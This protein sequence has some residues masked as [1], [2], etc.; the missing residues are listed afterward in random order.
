M[1]LCQY[2]KGCMGCCG[3]DFSSVKEVK[4]AVSLN[5]REFSKIK[6]LKKFRDRVGKWD[7]RSG[8]C[9][10]VVMVRK[11]VFCPLHP[12]R[13]SGKDLRKG[14]CD[15]K[16]LCAT[17][18]KFLKWDKRKQKEFLKFVKGMDT[19]EY[20]VGIDDGKLLKEFEKK[21]K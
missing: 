9:R 10:N 5:S 15:T 4:E 19:I 16:Y 21:E 1:I 12:K 2:N 8:V 17:A 18:K 6:N 7:L 13:N 11:R 3:Y 20:S 14:H